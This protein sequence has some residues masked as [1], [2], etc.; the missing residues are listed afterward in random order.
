MNVI[1]TR[2]A[3]ERFA[4]ELPA[5]VAG[6]RLRRL[7]ETARALYD[8][9][10]ADKSKTSLAGGWADHDLAVLVAEALGGVPHGADAGLRAAAETLFLGVRRRLIDALAHDPDDL[11]AALALALG[12]ASAT[13]DARLV[14]DLHAVTGSLARPQAGPRL[15]QAAV[16]L[17]LLASSR[18]SS[19][20]GRAI[21]KAAI[22]LAPAARDAIERLGKRLPEHPDLALDRIRL[23]VLAAR[24]ADGHERTAHLSMARGMLAD[25]EARFGP[26][27][28]Q[29][30]I[31]SQT[32][33]LRG[34]DAAPSDVA[35]DALALMAADA[36]EHALEP[37][38]TTK[39]LRAV[40]RAGALDKD[41]AK[42]VKEIFAD[43]PPSRGHA[44][45]EAW[46][47]IHEA[48]GDEAALLSLSEQALQRDPKDQ[49]AARALFERLLRNVRQRL[50]APFEATVL[51]LVMAAAPYQ[52]LGRVSADDVDALFHLLD[53]TFGADRVVAFAKRLVQAKEL[54][55]KDFVWRKALAAAERA[56][57]H[58]AIIDLARR[59]LQ[60][61]GAP[62]ETRLALARAL[63]ERGQDL[64]EAD[65]VLKPLVNE[66]GPHNN[67]AQ[68]LRQRIRGDA[69]Y[70]DARMQAL[71]AYEQQ[72]GIGTDKAHELRVAYTSPSYA[73]VEVAERPAPEFYE[74]KHLRVMLRGE[75]LPKGVSPGDL[76]K[77]DKL[78]A[79][80]RGQ[81]ASFEK[82]KDNY[83]IYWIADARQVKF[84]LGSDD[85]GKRLATEEA[86]FGI[87]SGAV[88]PLKVSWDGK[89]S[90]LSVRLVDKGG[91]EFRTRPSLTPEQ[92]PDGMAPQ[93]LG[94][95]GKRMW[96]VVERAG[97]GYVVSGKVLAQNPDAPA[98][99]TTEIAADTTDAAPEREAD[100]PSEGAQ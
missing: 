31:V 66:R 60:K 86:G 13:D 62:A 79:P 39:L 4:H 49:H 80:I 41:T 70:R 77:G 61:K 92:L 3:L 95:R 71:L 64:D 54:E 34:K 33:Q 47:M 22:D 83:R 97:D 68:A 18:P 88:V 9:A 24:S 76:K 38:R 67:E 23:T 37:R 20:Q 30:E 75:D 57:D 27:E 10:A 42:K 98:D 99:T 58:D 100:A 50:P 65:D 43:L 11:A 81:D 94:G 21:E 52:S 2:E 16:R 93:A 91:S 87:G 19:E 40:A 26:S 15:V 56:K 6:D 85:L 29:R 53:E 51:D 89:K 5:G 46:S 12:A 17:V 74:H 59:A 96:G 78:S 90:R 1:A 32:L 69:R 63:V 7:A 82:D 55:G 14:D 72:L 28:A 35:K 48:L 44:W 8:Q 45:D 73:L 84:A 36:K 25:H